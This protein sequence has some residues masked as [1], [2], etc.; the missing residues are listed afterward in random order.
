MKLRTP[1]IA[2]AAASSLVLAFL[3]VAQTPSLLPP[4][5]PAPRA[6][7][8]APPPAVA[9]VGP[10]G[11]ISREEYDVRVREGLDEYRRRSGS[12]VPSELRPLVRRQILESLVRR[13]LLL[14]EAARR[15]LR[16]TPEQ[17]EAELRATPFFNPGGAFDAA[18]WKQANDANP[19]MVREAVAELQRQIG[20]RLLNERLDR[21]FAP[22]E[23]ALR[24]DAARAL[25]KVAVD[26]L[27]LRL[28]DFSGAYPEPTEAEVLAAYRASGEAYRRPDRASLSVLVV[29]AAPDDPGDERA[30]AR[31]DSLARAL[32][33]GGDWN[34]A[35]RAFGA[36]RRDVVVTR[37]NFPGFWQ[38]DDRQ[39]R[40]VFE[41]RSGEVLAG[42]V[43]GAGGWMVVR[44]DEVRPSHVA[45]LRD[46]AR[47]VRA[48]LRR[49]ARDQADERAMA[50]LYA[51]LRDSLRAVA[52][53]LRYAA[54]DTGAL[55]PREPSESQLERWYRAHLADYSSFDPVTASIV[56]R[57]FAEVRGD[58]RRRALADE[59]ERSARATL[60]AIEKAWRAG[61]R[62]RNA[63]RAATV[64]REVAAAVPGAPVDTGQ[65][66]RTVGDSL[67]ARGPVAGLFTGRWARGPMLA[68]VRRVIPDF[69]PSLGLATPLLRS[70]LAARREREEERG[71]RALYEA[72]PDR[73]ARGR[74]FHFTRVIVPQLDVLDVPLTRAEVERYHREH[75]DRYYAPEE[76]RARH[77]LISPA[78]GG[79]E[80]DRAARA[81]AQALLERVRAG[82]DFATLARRHSQ[83]P[84]TQ[85]NGGDLGFFSRGAMLEAFER[86]AF[87]LRPGELGELVRTEV[88]Y[89]ILQ[90]TDH[91]PAVSQ[92]LA[93]IWSNVGADAALDKADSLSAAR[94][95]SLYARV[96]A[97]RDVRAAI[98]KLGLREE[99][100][101]HSEGD[102][103][104]LADLKPVLQTLERLSPGQ[105]YPGVFRLRGQGSALAWVDS[106]RPARTPRW[107]EAR[108]R[109]IDDYRARAGERALAAKAAELDSLLRAGWSFDSVAALWGG[110]GEATLGAGGGGLPGFGGG[111]ALD[112]LLFGA[113]GAAGPVLTRGR[114]GEWLEVPAGRVRVRPR[115]RLEPSATE[116]ASRMEADRERI[117][118]RRRWEYFEDLKKR[119]PVRIL[120]AGL[121]EVRLPEPPDR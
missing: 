60:E 80:A 83:D 49:E 119:F 1:S 27:G 56:A 25:G 31:A 58:V 110:L 79:E 57:P 116:L 20:A 84:A 65:V 16:G 34:A 86:A 2:A 69:T 9:T 115:E 72:D 118:Q 91:H 35:E 121:R 88:G 37:D 104:A 98:P 87:A 23:P 38:G 36:A 74:E 64:V 41:A 46:V 32:R 53:E 26:W 96:R 39:T 5:H 51:T 67:A 55:A 14:L 59:R 4:G 45:P 112:S 42:A 6:T 97:P 105:L 17:G 120:D 75:L 103:I 43:R 47:E 18:R 82:E 81:A 76:V 117:L 106:I 19:A 3:A 33:A 108:S 50:A 78:D 29:A 28:A 13:E 22:P 111:D 99:R 44:A 114:L 89:H 12:E 93:T 48:R 77:I 100:L 92:P 102:R 21:E 24:A 85:E 109:A 101:V 15:G 30:R 94:A 107:E 73:Y 90:V 40:A 68:E 54:V 62:D 10:S 8:Q 7:G 71:A 95:E 11:R 70:E 61:R 52:V 66:G 113:E 63:E